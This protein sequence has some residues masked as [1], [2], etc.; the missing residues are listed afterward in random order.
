MIKSKYCRMYFQIHLENKKL[1]SLFFLRNKIKIAKYFQN[2]T[3]NFF[4]FTKATLITI[5]I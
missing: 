2:L 1:N 3:I 4:D 5:S